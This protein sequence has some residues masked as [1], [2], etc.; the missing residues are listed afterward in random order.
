MPHRQTLCL[1]P[2][3]LGHLSTQQYFT[4]PK[5]R[6]RTRTRKSGEAEWRRLRK[7]RTCPICA[8]P[9]LDETA[10]GAADSI[11][12]DALFCEGACQCWH[13]RW[14][15]SVSKE[16]Y[17][18]LSDST[19]PFLCPSCTAANQQI[20]ILG[21]RDCLNALTDEVRVLKATVAALQKQSEKA[22]ILELKLRSQHCRGH[23]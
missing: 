2:Q 5:N 6:K 16:P 13:H 14:C 9:V 20:A 15:A 23:H 4:N 1:E 19:E 3:V 22:E 7:I 8:D 21:L 12:Q 18:A 11:A 17:A 10:T